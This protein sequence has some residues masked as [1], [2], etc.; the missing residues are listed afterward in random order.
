MT[1]ALPIFYCCQFIDFDKINSL[2]EIGSGSGK[3]IEVIKKLH[4][5]ID[6]YLFD[7][8]PQEYVCE[9]YLKA[10]FPTSVISYRIARN[11]SKIENTQKGSIYIFPVWK[12]STLENLNYDMF[13]N[14]ASFQEMEP[15][16]VLNY[17]TFVNQQTSKGIFLYETMTGKEIAANVGDHGVLNPTNI[18][19]YTQG[20]KDF[21]LCDQSNAVYLPNINHVSSFT[22]WKRGE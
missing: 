20:L 6:F 18:S 17:L 14:A 12:L 22:F 3:Q 10:V 4:P 5:N 2:A 13:W 1:C 19:H 11:I 16:I 9:Q 21:V 15:K 8:P 7:I